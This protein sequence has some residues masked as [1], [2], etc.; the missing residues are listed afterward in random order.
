[1]SGSLRREN[2]V[3]IIDNNYDKR[4]NIKVI[5]VGGGGNNAINRMISD[6]IKDVDF[7]AVNTDYQ[8]LSKSQAGILLQIGEKLT[9]GLGAGG[10]PEI[11]LKAAQESSEDIE[12]A[13]AGANMVFITAGMGGGTG[14]GAAPIIAQIARKLGILTVGVVT[15][16]FHF[17]LD[18]RMKNALL[19]IDELKKH[20]DSLIV[21]PNE[22]L[23]EIIGEEATHKE[24]FNKADE[25][26]RH[27]V[28]GISD[29]IVHEGL[30]NSDFADLVTIM[31]NK[32]VAHMGVG[33]AS[34]KNKVT[35]AADL[36]TKSP[37]L[38]TS[39]DGATGMLVVI[40]GSDTLTMSDI[41]KTMEL[42]T[43]FA[44]KSADV[45][46]GLSVDEKLDDEVIV[47][48]IATG[49][50][51]FGNNLSPDTEERSPHIGDSQPSQSQRI[52]IPLKAKPEV[53]PL[54]NISE[55]V[56]DDD[57]ELKFPFPSKP[58]R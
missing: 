30:I 36:A 44:D 54:K 23:L 22:K 39:I 32:G 45:I 33:R 16:P 43:N 38:E 7:I 52:K 47:T 1:M 46:F 50:E 18:K 8:V 20:V 49:I 31:K 53:V 28:Q 19:G 35:M 34:G 26:L 11:G 2:S 42:V 14:T 5:G 21:I 51:S 58:R 56:D 6:G 48:V 57:K 24:A 27:G 41:K 10:V 15:K 25:V 40:N 17:E 55:S 37:L 9:G 13:L 4:M 12:R 29:I 3:T